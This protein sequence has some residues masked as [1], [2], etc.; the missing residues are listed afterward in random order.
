LTSHGYP[1]EEA[2][3]YA[4]VGCVE[5]SLPGKSFF[6]TDAA[7]FNLPLCLE[8]ALN[9]GRRFGKHRRLGAETP[10]PATFTSI[11][12]VIEAFRDQV[13]FMVRRM[14]ADLKVM[15]RGNRDYHPT[16]FSSLLID[17][18]LETGKDVTA[19]GAMYNSSGVQGVGIA[20]VADSLAA[21]QEVVFT[22]KKYPLL[23]VSEAMKNNF[24]GDEVLRTATPA[25]AAMCRASIP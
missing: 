10:D 15:E 18:C 3:N 5:L 13:E 8:L 14:I 1:L 9:R 2:R 25:A 22:Q 17:G 23:S 24:A 16:P 21:L 20:D 7:L 19:G 4:V 6:S 12:R 11:D